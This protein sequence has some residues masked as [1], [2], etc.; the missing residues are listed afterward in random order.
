MALKEIKHKQVQQIWR[1]YMVGLI[2]TKQNV[3]LM[4]PPTRLLIRKTSP[5]LAIAAALPLKIRDRNKNGDNYTLIDHEKQ[6][7]HSAA[8]ISC[9]CTAWCH[10]IVQDHSANKCCLATV[11]NVC[12]QWRTMVVTPGQV[13]G[14]AVE[15]IPLN[16]INL[17]PRVC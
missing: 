17:G 6:V 1:R 9:S 12:W 4:E 3:L 16:N 7:V 15:C 10:P 14:A 13:G 5:R 8:R 11:W 2:K